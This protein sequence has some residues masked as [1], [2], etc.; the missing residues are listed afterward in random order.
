MYLHVIVAYFLLLWWPQTPPMGPWITSA[1]ATLA[2]VFGKIVLLGLAAAWVSARVRRDGIAGPRRSGRMPHLH[3]QALLVLSIV[4]VAGFAADL[5]L[6]VWPTMVRGVGPL[7]AVPGLE[8]LVI[9]LP[10]FVSI[11]VLWT[12]SYRVDRS[13]RE[14]IARMRQMET[15]GT[16][17]PAVWSLWQYLVFH[18]RHQILIAAIPMTIILVACRVSWRHQSWLV[19]WLKVPWA[20]QAVIG[21]AAALVFVFAPV[22][23]R[24]LWSTSPLPDGPLRRRLDDLCRRIGLRHR[25]ILVWHSHHMMVNAAVMGLFAPVRYVLLSDALLASLDA[26]RIEAVFGHEAGHVRLNH[27]PYFL[28]F[29]VSGMLLVSGFVEILIRVSA[30]A[31]PLIVL[32]ETGLQTAGFAAVLV[33]W[34]VGFGWVSRRFERQA[35]LWGAR[36]V[37]ASIRRCSLPCGRHPGGVAENPEPLCATAAATF[38]SA[39]D[40]VAVLNGIPHDE[41]SWRHSS[42]ASRMRFLTALVGD[43]V[44]LRSYDRLI[45]RIKLALWAAS[46]G[47]LLFAGWY[48]S[49]RPD[50]RSVFLYN[51]VDPFLGGPHRPSDAD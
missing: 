15:P 34:G 30:S 50:Y 45:R 23:L 37:T 11:I 3:H 8:D 43:V 33:V 42:I 5:G 2:F 10:F 35:D 51:F 12:A 21:L 41:R 39:L 36:Y 9:L 6:T 16:P 29:A 20:D 40:R 49:T 25:D 31:N 13:V 1:G 44:R 32:G 38:A 19:R 22:M 4:T 28:L 46:V 14:T 7:S 26:D 27:I 48:A 47:G 24:Y 17:R 18:L